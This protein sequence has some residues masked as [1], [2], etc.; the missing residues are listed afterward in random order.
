MHCDAAWQGSD[1][2]CMRLAQKALVS[3]GLLARLNNLGSKTEHSEEP[4]SAG[5][6]LAH[7]DGDLE[8]LKVDALAKIGV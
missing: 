6:W 7:G 1:E 3:S 2:E 4:F 8:P 5:A